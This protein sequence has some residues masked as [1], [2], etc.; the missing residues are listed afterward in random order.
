MKRI[1]LMLAAALLA[2]PAAAKDIDEQYAVFSVGGNPCSD[3]LAAR[4]AGGEPEQRHLHWIAGYLSAFN[5][6]V[7]GTYNILGQRD[8]GSFLTE[9]DGYCRAH[10]DELLVSALSVLAERM[11]P[12]RLNL[13]PN[14]DNRSKWTTNPLADTPATGDEP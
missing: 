2:A 1:V 7:P 13:S 11:Y 14:K 3:Y 8:F 10:R 9:L 4:E 12:D 5:Q 6:I